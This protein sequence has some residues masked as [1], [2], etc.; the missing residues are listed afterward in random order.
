MS[1][2]LIVVVVPAVLGQELVF[3]SPIHLDLALLALAFKLVFR[4]ALEGIVPYVAVDSV[5]LWT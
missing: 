5:C 4:S 3:A 1:A 2:L